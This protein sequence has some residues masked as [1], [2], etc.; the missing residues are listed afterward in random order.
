MMQFYD[1]SRRQPEL[2]TL[3]RELSWSHNLA[4][5]SRSKQDKEREFYLRMATREPQSPALVSPPGECP[6]S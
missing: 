4:I 2:A 3:S 6:P 5:M 1:T